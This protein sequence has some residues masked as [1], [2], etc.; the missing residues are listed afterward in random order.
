MHLGDAAVDAQR[1]DDAISKYSAYLLLNPA[2]PQSVLTKRS[3]VHVTMG[4]WEDALSDANQVG[5][6]YLTKI[7]FDA[8]IVRLRYWIRRLLGALAT[9]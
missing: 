5:H 1:Y 3:K 2:E 6:F 4:L 7:I 9:C 8:K